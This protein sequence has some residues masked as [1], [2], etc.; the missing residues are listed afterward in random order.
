[1]VTF[2]VHVFSGSQV[3][4]E[5]N[6]TCDKSCIKPFVESY[7]CP[8]DVDSGKKFATGHLFQAMF[9]SL[10]L[11]TTLT[12][13]VAI[14]KKTTTLELATYTLQRACCTNLAAYSTKVTT[15]NQ[16]FPLLL[17]W[18]SHSNAIPSAFCTSPHVQ[19][20]F[21]LTGIPSLHPRLTH[22]MSLSQLSLGSSCSRPL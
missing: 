8:P 19:N 2:V 11:C 14:K 5:Y 4:V 1:M 13:P 15:R 3:F 16:R 22:R 20:Q 9:S 7:K 6:V 17:Q 10:Y 12:I 21:H 18:F